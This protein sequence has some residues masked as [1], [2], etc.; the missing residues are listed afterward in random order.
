MMVCTYHPDVRKDFSAPLSP[1][2]TLLEL[3][4]HS[5][6]WILGGTCSG[7]ALFTYT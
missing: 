3:A 5:F 2:S 7:P 6:A 1:Y 4:I